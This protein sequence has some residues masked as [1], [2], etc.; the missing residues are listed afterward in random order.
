MSVQSKF[1]HSSPLSKS[2]ES[3]LTG[4]YL[5]SSQLQPSKGICLLR[6]CPIVKEPQNFAKEIIDY[7]LGMIT[8]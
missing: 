7:T 4:N 3:Y 6:G 1:I 8:G 5:T 2:T